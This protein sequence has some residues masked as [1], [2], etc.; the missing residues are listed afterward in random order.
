MMVA[1]MVATGRGGGRKRAAG[2]RV[3]ARGR[4]RRSNIE[5]MIK[6]RNVGESP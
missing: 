3:Y 2:A 6:G 4:K 1:L 5:R